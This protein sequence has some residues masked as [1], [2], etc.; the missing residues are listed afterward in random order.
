MFTAAEMIWFDIMNSIDNYVIISR[1]MFTA[2]SM[3]YQR[4]RKREKEAAK[5]AL[6]KMEVVL[7]GGRLKQLYLVALDNSIR[8]P[9]I[10]SSKVGKF[11][12]ICIY[13]TYYICLYAFHSRN[14]LCQYWD[15]A[16]FPKFFPRCK[17]DVSTFSMKPLTLGAEDWLAICRQKNARLRKRLILMRRRYNNSKFNFDFNLTRRG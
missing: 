7:F 15:W 11:I 9:Q 5:R 8:W 16:L 3:T 6:A 14:C 13:H 4:Q 10:I 17:R 2:A 12:C 1:A